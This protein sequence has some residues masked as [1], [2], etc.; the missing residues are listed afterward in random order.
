MA[1]RL[2]PAPPCHSA[3]STCLR[4]PSRSTFC[5][6][7][8]VASLRARLADK[9]TPYPAILDQLDLG[10]ALGPGLNRNDLL[11]RRPDDRAGGGVASRFILALEQFMASGRYEPDR[12]LF[13]PVPK[14]SYASRP[15][16]LLT[17]ADRVVFHALVEPLRPRIERGLVSTSSLLWPRAETIEK[18]WAHFEKAPTEVS[19]SHIIRADVAGFYESVDHDILGDRLIELTGKTQLVLVLLEFLRQVMQSTAGLPQG[20]AA[21]DVLATTYLSSVDSGMLRHGYAYWRHGDDV[22]ITVKNHDEGRLAVHRFESLLRAVGLLLNS[23][24][25]RVLQRPTYERQ[26]TAVDAERAQVRQ[27]L[28]V[29]REKAILEGEADTEEVQTLIERAGID[30]QTQWDL[31]YHGSLSLEDIVENLRPHLQ[32]DDVSVAFATFSEALRRAPDADTDDPPLSGEMFH[33]MLA[34]SLTTLI[35][36]RDARPLSEIG[37]LIG[38]FPSETELLATYLRS[39][40]A[41]EP[42]EV[43]NEVTLALSAGYTTGWQQAWL[44]GAVR[45]VIAAAPSTDVQAA[46]ELAAAIAADEEASWLARA[47]AAR[48]LASAGWLE[49]DLL[50]RL[51]ARAPAAVRPDLALAVAAA[52]SVPDPNSRPAWAEAF[53]DSLGDDAM[54]QVVLNRA[55]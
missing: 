35:A 12:A 44:L 52:A 27:S 48:V 51:W 49:Q 22:R 21:S 14:P 28:V 16:A 54:L 41:Q 4:L 9:R 11:P 55:S 7:S 33:G 31:F 29:A 18:Q 23:E 17:A 8:R 26:M 10:A 53:R 3:Y 50:R 24:K 2:E 42:S 1:A 43:V 19:G 32:P 5:H 38:R 6:A 36:A 15:A 13:V 34:S 40:A 47:E 37:A 20:L 45:E 39:T 25:T 30:D 46:V